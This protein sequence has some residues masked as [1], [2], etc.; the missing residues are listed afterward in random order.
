MENRS[1]FIK[2]ILE[3]RKSFFH[4]VPTQADVPPSDELY[5]TAHPGTTAHCLVKLGVDMSQMNQAIVFS[6]ISVLVGQVDLMMSWA[7]SSAHARRN[8]GHDASAFTQIRQIESDPISELI[9]RK[10]LI[11]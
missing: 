9:D 8:S 2:W 10:T 5:L 1:S 7:N 11:I 4:G 6:V 3:F